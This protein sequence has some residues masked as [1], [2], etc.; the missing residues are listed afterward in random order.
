M[1]MHAHVGGG[2]LVGEKCLDG[3]FKLAIQPI[4]FKVFI[5]PSNETFMHWFK[6]NGFHGLVVSNMYHDI[7]YIL[8]L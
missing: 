8:D 7:E 1:A 4:C 6:R 2:C 5:T 3:K